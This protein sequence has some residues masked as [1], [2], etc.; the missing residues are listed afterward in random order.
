MTHPYAN[1]VSIEVH[2]ASHDASDEGPRGARCRYEDDEDT[3]QQQRI[4]QRGYTAR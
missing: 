1:G 3:I 2:D 4:G